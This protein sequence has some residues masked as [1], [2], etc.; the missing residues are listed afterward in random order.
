[1]IQ[2]NQSEDVAESK[3]SGCTGE[4]RPCPLPCSCAPI[5]TVHVRRLLSGSWSVGT[6][7]PHLSK[8]HYIRAEMTPFQAQLSV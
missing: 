7:V 3:T 8:H 1:M 4:G 5:I 6:D 2:I